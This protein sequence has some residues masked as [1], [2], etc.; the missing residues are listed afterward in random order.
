MA[1]KTQVQYDPTTTPTAGLIVSVWRGDDANGL[2]QPAA[3]IATLVLDGSVAVD[4]H[5]QRVDPRQTPPALTAYT[6]PASPVMTR[7]EFLQRFTADER[8][9]IRSSADA[10]V[11]D[12][13]FVL[14]HAEE[15][16]LTSALTTQSVTYLVSENLLTQARA[17]AILTP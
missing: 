15:M 13:L 9:A 17:T 12:F 11:Q 10:T 3:P 6:P 8:I 1:L 16:D 14:A 2:P 5:T 4:A 7:V